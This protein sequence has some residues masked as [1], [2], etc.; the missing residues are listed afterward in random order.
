[1]EWYDLQLELVDHLACRIEE[2][3]EADRSLNFE[4]ALAKVY[5]GFGLFG[6]AKVVQEKQDQLQ[7][8]AR[9][10]W[11]SEIK[12]FFTWPKIILLSLFAF[13]LWQLSLIFDPT[14]LMRGFAVIYVLSSVAFLI[15]V[16]RSRKGQHKLLLLQ[17]GSSYISLLVFFYEVGILFRFDPFSKIEFC[18]YATV[19]ILFKLAS[20]QVYNKV[21]EQAVQLYPDAFA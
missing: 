1:M 9:R 14:H 6:F 16:I 18:I 19:G 3:M 11:W 10:I 12:A 5:K 20:F 8:A 17:S 13:A 21:K 7:K 15:Y 2:E 4:A